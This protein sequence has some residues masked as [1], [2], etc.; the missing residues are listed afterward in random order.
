MNQNTGKYLKYAVGEI[1]LVM[2][3][4]L[5]ALALNDWHGKRLETISLSNYYQEMA[6]E[7]NVIAQKI[8]SKDLTKLDDLIGEL[9][10]VIRLISEKPV[11]FEDSLILNLGPIG[12]AWQVGIVSPVYNEFMSS[13]ML[14]KVKSTLLKSQLIQFESDV[15]RIK[16]MDAYTKEQYTSLLEPYITKN[17]NYSN[18]ALLQYQ[19][20]L[21]QGGPKSKITEIV[22]TMEFWN[23]VTFKLE[24]CQTNKVELEILVSHLK[25]YSGSLAAR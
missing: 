11:H 17:L 8:E 20:Y 10:N 22:D 5:L 15:E 9:Q 16:I 1:L 7:F 21:I 13:G 23:V 18:I 2:V 6:V 14:I 25:E 3:G 12:T 19:D 4:I 24:T